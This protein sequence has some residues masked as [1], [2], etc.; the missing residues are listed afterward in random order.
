[1]KEPKWV[2]LLIAG[3]VFTAVLL[4]LMLLNEIAQGKIT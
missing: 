2:L 3:A 1:M 4:A